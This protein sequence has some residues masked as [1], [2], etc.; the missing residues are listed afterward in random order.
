LL[1][2][3]SPDQ[4]Q[5]Y[6]RHTREQL[7][8]TSLSSAHAALTASLN[9]TLDSR[10]SAAWE[11]RKRAILEEVGAGS[12]GLDAL[13][14]DGESSLAEN[15]FGRSGR[16]R[17]GASR[18]DFGASLSA[19]G[20]GQ[21]MSSPLQPGQTL[22]SHHRA[23][24][25]SPLVSQ[26]NLSRK[27]VPA[28]PFNVLSAYASLLAPADVS[29]QQTQGAN[30]LLAQSFTLLARI[31]AE[32]QPG[33]SERSYSAGYTSGWEGELGREVRQRIASGGKE[34]LEEQYWTYIGKRVNANPVQAGLGGDPSVGNRVRGFAR[35]GLYKDGRWGEAVEVRHWL[36]P[37]MCLDSPANRRSAVHM[38]AARQRSPAL[39]RALL[40]PPFGSPARG[41]RPRDG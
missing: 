34:F 8:L 39:R 21:S 25:Y 33:V 16:G 26:L 18:P 29:A 30:P 5:G 4:P 19:S 38:H 14:Q 27:A 35:V 9:E 23:L 22:A 41:A 13:G 17:L 32:G 1:T 12:I 11:A 40:P 20:L 36:D 24:K 28:R 10:R 31:V 6:L 7:I 37:I 15:G 2:G 3:R